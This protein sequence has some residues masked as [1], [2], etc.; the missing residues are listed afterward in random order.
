MKRNTENFVID[1]ISFV[2]LLALIVTGLIIKYVLPPGTGG[3][4]RLLHGGAGRQHLRT[5]FSMS[6]H[7]WGDIHFYLAVCFIVLMVV[8]VVLHWSWVR[9]CTKSV[10][11]FPKKDDSC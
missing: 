6:R 9:N 10:F 1:C 4:G 11:H 5:L 3:Q 2:V 7:Q 8:H